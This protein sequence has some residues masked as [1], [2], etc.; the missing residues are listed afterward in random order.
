[1]GLL[2]G[3][4]KKLD[5]YFL[6]SVTTDKSVS[7]VAARDSGIRFGKRDVFLDRDLEQGTIEERLRL[8]SDLAEKKGYA[9]G[10]AHPSPD[11]LAVLRKMLPILSA[12]GFE[13]V[14]LSQIIRPE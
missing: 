12:Q 7:K 13:V 10:I 5:L 9:I 2:L 14:S 3:E 11:T 8:L 4:L 6:D 1:M